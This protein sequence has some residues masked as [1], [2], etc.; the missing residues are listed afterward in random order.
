MYLRIYVTPFGYKFRAIARVQEI[1]GRD[2]VVDMVLYV[3]RYIISTASLCRERLVVGLSGDGVCGVA[4]VD[5]ED[6]DGRWS[7]KKNRRLP[8]TGR[9]LILKIL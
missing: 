1:Y 8:V 9:V 6:G 3:Q 2:A 5:C 7:E 4:S